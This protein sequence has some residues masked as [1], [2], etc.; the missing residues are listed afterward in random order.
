MSFMVLCG[1]GK[2]DGNPSFKFSTDKFYGF[3]ILQILRSILVKYSDM[4]DILINLSIHKIL[5]KKSF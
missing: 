1:N 2:I 3:L 5:H 4:L